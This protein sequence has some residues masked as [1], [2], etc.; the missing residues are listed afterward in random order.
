MK[1]GLNIIKIILSPQF[2]WLGGKGVEFHPWGLG[3]K[4][5]KWLVQ[6]TKVI[7]LTTWILH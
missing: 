7:F 5:H 4:L 1:Y 3:I 2:G 6:L